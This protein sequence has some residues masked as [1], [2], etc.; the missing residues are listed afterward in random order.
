MPV[1]IDLEDTANLKDKVFEIIN[2]TIIRLN[3]KGAVL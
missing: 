3:G 1:A 2:S